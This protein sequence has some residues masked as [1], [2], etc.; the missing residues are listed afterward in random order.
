MK[1]KPAEIDRFIKSPPDTVR[2]ALIYGPDLGLVRERARALLNALTDTPDDPFSVADVEEQTL[3]GDP[4]R[5]ADE[6]GAVAMFGG[7]RVVRVRDAGEAAAKSLDGYLKLPGDGFVILEAGDLAPRSALRKLTEASKQA[8]ALP[9]YSD[10]TENLERL[11]ASMIRE[12]GL[13]I[14]APVLSTLVEQLGA[15]RQLSRNEIEKLILY[16]G[17]ESP[18]TLDDI[19]ASV[20]GA[21]GRGLDDA[22]D[23]AAGGDMQAFDANFARLIEAGMAPDRIIRTLTMHMQRLHL[24]LGRVERGGRLDEIVRSLRP[25]LHF[26]RQPA[27]RRQ[28]A[29]WSRR[30]LDGALAMLADAEAQCRG[31]GPLSQAVVARAMMSIAHAA[32]AGRRG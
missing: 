22:I 31:A 15:D 29:V 16:K 21:D 30:R 4:A 24:V 14:D 17:G 2:A 18:V 28:C 9:C 23:S 7:R 1:L 26:S 12:A 20:G 19:A 11:A 27:L 8:A 25:P 32:A 13:Q 10:T 5:L 6:A 3:K